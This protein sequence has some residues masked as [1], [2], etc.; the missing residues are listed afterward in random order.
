MCGLETMILSAEAVSYL[1]NLFLAVSL[2]GGGGLLAARV[3]RR[4]PAPLR[5]D[6]LLGTLALILFS[7]VAVWLAQG[8]SLAMVHISISG[9]SNLPETTISDMTLPPTLPSPARLSRRGAEGKHA[10]DFVADS[11]RPGHLAE[12]NGPVPKSNMTKAGATA[13]L[14]PLA[15]FM[16]LAT[17]AA[18]LWAIG[19]AAG[20]VWLGWGFIA[21][22]RFCR[23][24]EP[25]LDAQK[26]LLVHQAA[27][28]VGLRRLPGVFLTRL[29][30][31]PMSLGLLRPAI[32]LPHAMREMDKEQ[33]QAVLLHEMAHIARGDRW[34]GLGQRIAAALFWWNPLVHRLCDQISDLREE[35]CDNHVVLVQGE[36]QGLALILVDL[37]AHVTSGR[38]LPS[39]IGVIE[40]RL[41][42]LTGRVT[43][44]LN[45]ERNMETRINVR[46]KVFLFAS[47]LVI[48]FA[49]ST[50]GGLRLAQAQSTAGHGTATSKLITYHAK[51]TPPVRM[52]E[53]WVQ[54]NPDGTPVRGRVDQPET[55]DGSK[56]IFYSEGRVAVWFKDK[57]GF[58]ISPEKDALK[59]VKGF[60]L[61]LCDPKQAFEQL[62]A[63]EKAGQV[64]IEIKNA[65]TRKGLV[66][67]IVTPKDTTDQREIYEVDPTTKLC[68]RITYY[69][70][71]G[72]QWK[73][74]KIAEILRKP[75]SPKVFDPD[76]PEDVSVS[77]E[78]NNPPGLL[79]QGTLTKEEIATKV[80]R[81]F[82]EALIAKDYKK[83]GLIYCGIPAKRIKAG[84]GR[85]H[86]ERIV[87]I[88]KPQ[89]GVHP[90]PSTFAV[91]VKVECGPKEWVQDYSPQVRLTD[92][93]TAIKEVREFF[94]ALVQA[95][96]KKARKMLDEGLVFE[97]FSGKNA[98]KL[99]DF[100][101]KYKVLR[102]VEVGKPAPYPGSDRLEVPAKVEIEMKK[103]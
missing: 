18:F 12:K 43:R 3:C 5:H 54:V 95:D 70:R 35:I 69:S 85:L 13:S 57:K 72:A 82:F 93:K 44:L 81:G 75:I 49:I 37:A 31:V 46:S 51:L 6:V 41:T 102:I 76:L 10:Q 24:M 33:F 20:L 28:A 61:N 36:G 67:L 79:V 15:W 30:S 74:T 62:K 25:L 11:P 103:M 16:A 38:P 29:A 50:V 97:G 19:I 14:G 42:G 56:V 2:I 66:R 7:P 99:K 101:E 4:G 91:L 45:K 77:D 78:I 94:E 64:N 98:E 87:D 71:Q 58:S 21:L 39:A 1:L 63:R 90:D 80:A 89:T 73:Q 53:V 32:V 34:V 17:T 27:D 40:P 60:L 88:E 100:F 86:I 9:E 96:E 8:N 83:A 26:K 92:N 84:L 47:S 65:T 22:A 68:E 23:R 55:E 48:L 52:S 59:R